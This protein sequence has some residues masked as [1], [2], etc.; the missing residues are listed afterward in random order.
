N[1]SGGPQ[2]G[3]Q[4][5]ASHPACSAPAREPAARRGPSAARRLLARLQSGRAARQPGCI[6]V[7]RAPLAG[8]AA[9]PCEVGRRPRRGARA[10]RSAG[11]RLRWPVSVGAP[12]LAFL[13]C[14]AH[15]K[16]TM[17]TR[18]E[19]EGT[20]TAMRPWGSALLLLA[21]LGCTIGG[22]GGTSSNAASTYKDAHA[23][24]A[25]TMTFQTA[26]IGTYGGRFILG[27]TSGPKSFNAIMANETSTT[28]VT[29]LLFTT[30]A[31][32][33]N[34]TQHD[35]PALAKSW[36]VT[37]DGLTWTWHMR[38]G[39]AF[40][41]GHPIT[42]ED[43]LFS[44]KV[45]YDATLHPSIQDL[46]IVNGKPI[47]VSAPDSYTVVMKIVS[48]YAMMIPA[49]GSLR[50]MPK[51]I[52]QSS[53]ESGQFASAYNTNISADSL[54]TSGAWRLKQFVP[55]EKTVL[56]RNPYWY[57]V[58]AKGH[59]LPYLDELVFLIVPDQNAAALKFRS[60]ELDGLDNVRPEDYQ[61]YTDRQKQENF[62]LYD[63]GPALNTNFFWFN[64]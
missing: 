62:T 64:L 33:N 44:F 35:T 15:A 2:A 19:G 8:R 34:G 5:P 55:G 52:L 54:V 49:V 4:R 42:S 48:P 39:A 26:E 59:R 38:H 23:L 22:C 25:D 24:P 1:R 37:P 45:A 31:D 56:T 6:G 13:Y 10:R 9:R 51:H 18:L 17:T 41:D 29:Q 57:G 21:G 11:R 20:M 60:G 43:V 7:P 61:D 36:D 28:D 63:L 27:Q 14:F 53:F 40:S 58:D 12:K 3:R 50:I 47:E 46:L 16:R 30:L 32:F